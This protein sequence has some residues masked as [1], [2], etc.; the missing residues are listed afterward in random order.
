M[1]RRAHILP[2]AAALA[3]VSGPVL[4]QSVEA[5]ARPLAFNGLAAPGCIMQAPSSPSSSNA[6]VTSVAPGAADILFG[7]LVGEDG[8]PVGATV[9]LTVP[10]ACN[11]AHVLTL[12]STS[13]GLAN[14]DGTPVGGPFRALLP[15]VATVTWGVES[16]TYDSANPPL[17]I[18]HGDAAVGSITV[19]IEIPAGGAPLVAGAYS[20]QLVLELA[21][22][23]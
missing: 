5:P 3:M 11:Q 17:T 19:I 13:G 23:G 14:L 10:A 2:V 16:E 7:Q 6:S 9:V 12:A 18:P 8:V 4:A 21:A 1:T 20:D 22:A 15:Y